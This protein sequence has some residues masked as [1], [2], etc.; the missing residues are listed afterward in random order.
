[1]AQWEAMIGNIGEH[2]L[3]WQMQLRDDPAADID[4]WSDAQRIGN[5]HRTRVQGVYPSTGEDDWVAISIGSDAE[6]AALCGVM[7]R[8]DLIRDPR[9]AD[10]VS[11]RHHQDDLDPVIAEWTAARSQNA[12]AAELQNAG[13]SA[14]PVLKIQNLMQDQHLRARGF[15]ESVSHPTAGAWDMEGPVWR[16]SKT[17]AH[18]RLPAPCFGEHNQWVLSDL[19]GLSEDE[20][21]ALEADGVT[22]R[23]PNLGVH[24]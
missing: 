24:S 22:A 7:G 4:T 3:A 9:F 18:V 10:V 12:A 16:M 5:R 8:P 23:E 2:I 21:A 13:V 14:A 19:L 11:R 15:W 6:H 17:P 20:I 1:V